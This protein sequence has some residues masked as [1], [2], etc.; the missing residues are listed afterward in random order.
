MGFFQHDFIKLNL[1][2]KE[3]CDCTLLFP[4]VKSNREQHVESEY[5]RCLG[6][7]LSDSNDNRLFFHV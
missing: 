3:I 6:I 7:F 4:V 5:F 2:I 1:Q